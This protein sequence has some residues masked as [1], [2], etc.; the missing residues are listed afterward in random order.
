MASTTRSTSATAPPHS[1]PANIPITFETGVL[2]ASIC[3][4]IGLV[5]LAGLPRL[6]H[7]VFEVEAF[8]TASV[9]GFWLAAEVVP[10][11]EQPLLDELQRLGAAQTSFVT[12]GK[13]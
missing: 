5:A 13:R 1:P 2:I 12:E 10:G 4:V 6:Y 8:R 11:N 7:P 3:I 9:D